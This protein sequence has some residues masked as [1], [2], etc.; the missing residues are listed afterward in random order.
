MKLYL[1]SFKLGDNPEQLVSLVGEGKKA[2]VILNALDY[3][4]EAR[5]R[6]F[7]S[8][9]QALTE[10][11]FTVEELD[12]RH[13]FGKQEELRILLNTKDLV[14]ING[15]NTFILRRAMRQSG[16]DTI[17]TDLIKKESIVYGGFSAAVCILAP[18]LKGLDITDD[19]NVVPDGYDKEIIWDGLGI[20]DYSVAVHYQ[21]DHPE[22]HLTDKE[23]AFYE[24]NDMPYK[25][26][27]DGE[28]I[29]IQ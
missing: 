13:Y 10:L 2:V 20:I 16:F 11:G 3:K 1:S 23:I 12:L 18:T 5:A 15:G 22:S 29:V 19:P 8:Q 27:R 9:K 25:K 24:E 28:V 14:W 7:A 6:F 4:D 26:L 17:I 21:S